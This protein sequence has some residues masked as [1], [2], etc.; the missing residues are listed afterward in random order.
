MSAATKLTTPQN[1]KGEKGISTL[2]K[3]RFVEFEERVKSIL[4]E[5]EE[6]EEIMIAMCEVMKFDPSV[7]RYCEDI[8]ERLVENNRKWR[9]RKKDE[10]STVNAADAKT[11]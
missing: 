10:R 4:G 7:P 1:S 5:G 3:K 11:R 6:A 9:R 8:R 2:S